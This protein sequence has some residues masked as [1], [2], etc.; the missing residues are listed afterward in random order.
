MTFLLAGC[1]S[2]PT[3]KTP[4]STRS[5]PATEYIWPL[6]GRV[7]VRYGEKINHISSNGIDI[8][9]N[10]S[11]ANA[12][13]SGSVKFS[14]YLKGYGKTVIIEHT[15]GIS[16]VYSNLSEIYVKE[17]KYVTQKTPLGTV[18]KNMYF[19]FEIRQN[20][21]PQDPLKYLP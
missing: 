11:V 18:A 15:S 21:I 4:K 8:K 7:I 17:G 16:S 13:K 10:N 14:R 12:I 5:L 3:T 6:E 2:V 9:P 19:H 1:A 20:G